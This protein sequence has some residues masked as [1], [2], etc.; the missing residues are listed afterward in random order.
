MIMNDIY[1]LA[2][3]FGVIITMSV[4]VVFIAKA[5]K[6]SQADTIGDENSYFLQK[7]SDDMSSG[8]SDGT[9]AD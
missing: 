5:M 2:F 7:T 1:A 8:A 9:S 6:G 4:F 3:I